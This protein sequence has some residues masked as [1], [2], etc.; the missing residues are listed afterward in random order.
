MAAGEIGVTCAK[1]SEAEVMAAAGIRDLLI[2]NMIVGRPKLER[3]VSLCR[4]RSDRHL[5]SPTR[6]SS[7]WPSCVGRTASPV[8]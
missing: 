7:R 4:G 2:A 5:R 8:A 1:V 6:K 3:V